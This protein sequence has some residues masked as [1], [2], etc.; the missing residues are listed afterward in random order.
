MAGPLGALLVG[1]TVFTIDVE[2]DVD[3][4]PLAGAIGG[5]GSDYHRG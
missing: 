2:E 3:G 4:G 1:S 5:S